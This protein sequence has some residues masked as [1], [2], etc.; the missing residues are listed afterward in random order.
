MVDFLGDCRFLFFG[1]QIKA[2]QVLRIFCRRRLRKMHNI[3]RRLAGIY[4]PLNRRGN[5]IHRIGKIQRNRARFSRYRYAGLSVQTRNS[6]FKKIGFANCRGHQQKSRLGKSQKRN[7]PSDSA[8]PV[9]IIVKFV[10][11]DILNV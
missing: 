2:R 5:F 1:T 7:L 8:F 4:K 10:H 6:L 11:H 3:N 9:R